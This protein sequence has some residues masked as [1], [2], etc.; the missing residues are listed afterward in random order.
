MDPN[1]EQTVLRAIAVSSLY[2]S[3]FSAADRQSAFAILEE[4]KKFEGRIAVCVAWIQSELHVY[5]GSDITVATK[6][7]ALELLSSFL[8]EKKAGNYSYSSLSEQDRTTLRQAVL[9][10]ARLL[11]IQ[12]QQPVDSGQIRILGRKLAL[13]I[14]SIAIR[15]FPQR[16]TTFI[17]DIFAPYS[18]G[19][20][21]YDEVSPES[22][23][24]AGIKICLECLQLLAEDCTDSDFNA[25]VP[26]TRRND[27]LKGLNEVVGSFLPLLYQL[28]EHYVFLQQSQTSLFE[29]HKYL[30]T[31]NRTV[32]TLSE[33]EAASYKRE[34]KRA[35]DLAL[36]IADTLLLLQKFCFSMPF[37]WIIGGSPDFILPLLHLLREPTAEIQ[38]KA[39]DC[40]DQLVTRGKLETQQWIDLLGKLPVAVQEA[41]RAF[42]T[43]EEFRRSEVAAEGDTT[44]QYDSLTDQLG[45]HKALSRLLSN[46]LSSYVTYITSS[47]SILNQSGTEYD[48]FHAFTLLTVEMLRHPSGKVCCQQLHTWTTLFRDPQIAQSRLL[49]PYLQDIILSFMNHVSRIRW[50]DVENE[51]HP[52]SQLLEASFEDSDGYD[53]WLSDFRSRSSAVFKYAGTVEPC[54]VAQTLVARM[55]SL[56]Q[57]HANGEPL[58]FLDSSNGQV[59]QLSDAVIQ[60]EGIAL[61]MENLLSGL[62][63]WSMDDNA[64]QSSNQKEYK[65]RLELRTGTK[66]ALAELVHSVVT[67]NPAHLWLR[68]RRTYLLE[69]L[70]FVWKYDSSTLLQG[71]ESLIGYLGLKDEWTA[72]DVQPGKGLSPEITGLKKRSGS[73]LVTIA[74]VV[75]QHLVP[76]LSQ[77]SNATSSL[78]AMDGLIPLNQTH[79][80]EFLSCVATA[81]DDHQARSNFIGGVLSTAIES[82]EAL[83]IQRWVS[84]VPS[85]LEYLGVA[86]IASNPAAATDPGTVQRITQNYYRVFTPLNQLLSVGKRCQEAARKKRSQLNP[87]DGSIMNIS[88]YS[89]FTFR[90]E[91]PMSINDLAVDDPFVPLW[92]RFLPVLLQI[93]EVILAVWR[94]EQQSVFLRN[95]YQ[96]YLFAISEDEAFLSKNHDAQSGGVFGEGGTAGSV[97]T[98]ASRRDLNLVPKWSGWFNELRNTCFQLLGLLCTQKVLFA[99]EISHLYPRLVTLLTEPSSLR[100]ME[101]RHFNQFMKHVVTF[102]LTCTPS[103]LYKTHIEPIMSPIFD[104]IRFR[105]EKTWDPVLNANASNAVGDSLSPR[106]ALTTPD[107]NRAA[108]L[109]SQGSETWYTWYYG[110]AGLFVGEL[111]AVTSEAAVEK[112][113]VELSRT[114]SDV[115]QVALALKGDW[116]LVLANLARDEQSSKRSDTSPEIVDT[117]DANGTT[118]TEHEIYEDARKLRRIKGLCHFLFLESEAIASSL[119]LSIIQCL[120]YPDAYTC[121]RVTKIC[122]RILEATAWSP[123]YVQL[124]GQQMFSQAVK[125]VVTE[126]KW[127]VGIEWDMINVIRDIYCRMVLGQTLQFG[128]QGPASQQS[129]SGP[130]TFE[131]AKTVDDPLHGG[132][133]QV[134]PCAH[135]RQILSCLPGVSHGVIT[136]FEQ[137]MSTKRSAKDQKEFVRELLRMIADSLSDADANSVNWGAAA[138]M[139]DR[140]GK[141][142]SLLHLKSRTPTIPDL[143][144]KLVTYSDAQKA[145]QRAASQH[146]GLYNPGVL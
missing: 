144:E 97:V 90:D 5:E 8:Q 140:A 33:D 76:W 130:S 22:G 64:K 34:K 102:I 143:P 20:L 124:L 12:S 116:A 121:R 123:H 86:D 120:G 66:A 75:P 95:P 92:P 74:K 31:Q 115:L 126:P 110:H 43:V 42:S 78:L 23:R 7:L 65:A 108:L 142:E 51:T 41:N 73:A 117:V 105:L 122:H 62:P 17:A 38:V 37:S 44:R 9:T 21:W 109:A 146:D 80:F 89:E 45:Y 112:S 145:N 118:R 11:C 13:I 135:P 103:T 70:R 14:E 138:G 88:M 114:F 83:D 68:F 10:S 61:P 69:P 58:N 79:L 40:L 93:Y 59:T 56:L 53:A 54:I 127:M 139:L 52:F 81:V 4:F 49:A 119:T 28:L 35:E 77:L 46:H 85:F 25:K 94:P 6:L 107:C 87:I 106:K 111:D 72:T 137:N 57:S 55:K 30:I 26:T 2:N 36:L 125:N 19:G 91:G 71:V 84:S 24:N 16:W 98:G 15:D 104:H 39:I 60:F 99:P 82:L 67:W 47:K 3:A 100:S 1:Q 32:H 133:I 113:V 50:E 48:I 132:G 101:H 29:M 134:T 141:D 128:G 63:S 18:Q 131:Q 96:R 136:E 129:M 27:I